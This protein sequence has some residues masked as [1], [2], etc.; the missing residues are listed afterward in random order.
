MNTAAAMLKIQWA[1]NNTSIVHLTFNEL[2]ATLGGSVE[3]NIIDTSEL[4]EGEAPWQKEGFEWNDE[5]EW[6]DVTDME[7]LDDNDMEAYVAHSRAHHEH[8]KVSTVM[9]FDETIR[10]SL[11]PECDRLRAFVGDCYVYVTAT[12]EVTQDE[13][14]VDVCESDRQNLVAMCYLHILDNWL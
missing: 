1:E 9:A 14:Y 10:F 7:W 8:W 5:K 4:S 11:P 3:L 6:M 2:R 12:N 13:V